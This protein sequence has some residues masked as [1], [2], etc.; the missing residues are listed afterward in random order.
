[1]SKVV[2]SLK[3]LEKEIEKE[4]TYVLGSAIFD[5]AVMIA[6]QNVIEEVYNAYGNNKTG[7]PNIYVRRGDQNGGL[8]DAE[9][10]TKA[11]SSPMTLEIRNTAKP[12]RQFPGR[13]KVSNLAML[14]ELG[15]NHG[16]RYSWPKGK[17][18]S[19][20]FRNPR[21]FMAKT[22]KFFAKNDVLNTLMATSL[23]ARGLTIL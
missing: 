10:F 19:G 20:D 5:F 22:Q 17:D 6:Q 4:V 21:P 14:V 16:G 15:N 3:A 23:K 13:E 12:N 2:T 18:T 9:S 1:M 7:Q 11:L 8:M